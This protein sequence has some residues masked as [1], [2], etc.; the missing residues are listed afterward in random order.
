MRRNKIEKWKK[1][2]YIFCLELKKTHRKWLEGIG[3]DRSQQ[4]PDRKIRTARYDHN[5]SPTSFKNLLN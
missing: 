5:P 2:I 3:S 1:I 4:S